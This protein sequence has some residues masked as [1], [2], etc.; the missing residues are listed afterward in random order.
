MAG[1]INGAQWG[2]T[3]SPNKYD[4]NYTT[5]SKNYV[6]PQHFYQVTKISKERDTNKITS[7]VIKTQI[8]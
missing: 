6:R 7:S 4:T 3:F 5:P 1:F 2:Y 8:L